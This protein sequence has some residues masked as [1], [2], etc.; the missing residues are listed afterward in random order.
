MLFS[1]AIPLILFNRGYAKMSVNFGYIRIP[2]SLLNDPL[3]KKLSLAYQHI[4]IVLIEHACYQPR[5]FD[6]HGEIIELLPGQI[7]ISIREFKKLCH[8][9]I[10][11]NDIERFFLKLKLYGFLRLEVRHRKSIITI[12]H[13]DTYELIKQVHETT[14]ETNLRQT[15]DKLETQT[16]KD[17]KEKKDKNINITTLLD[18]SKN[19][20]TTSD[21]ICYVKLGIANC[22]PIARLTKAKNSRY[23]NKQ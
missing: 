9:Q 5:K 19:S 6:D 17:N 22:L 21:N 3:W 11:K 8:D 13:P 14:N 20:F 23:T 4:F 16:N 1:L 12:T 15:R 2:R 7:C 10:S 18:D